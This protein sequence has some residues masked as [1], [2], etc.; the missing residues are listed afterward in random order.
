[1]KLF[2]ISRVTIFFLIIFG[3]FANF[4]QNDWGNTI[5][6][7]GELLIALL[8]L[9]EYCVVLF[10]RIRNKEARYFNV[11][12]LLLAFAF[13]V[14]P[15][16]ISMTASLESDK[17][18]N[19]Y[20][21]LWLAYLLIPITDFALCLRFQ[22]KRRSYTAGAFEAFFLFLSF[23]GMFLRNIHMPLAG[24]LLVL[25]NLFMAVPFY[26]YTT[27]AFAR[28]NLKDG[29]F[30]ITVLIIGSL[31]AIILGLAGGFKIMHLP[32]GTGLQEVGLL[33][34][35]L[36]LLGAMRW[37]FKFKGERV[38]ILRALSLFETRIV[39]VYIA[40][41]IFMSHFYLVKNGLAPAFYER[42]FPP[43]VRELQVKGKDAQANEVIE[44][45][46]GFE[47]DARKNGFL[48]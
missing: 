24:P 37:Q 3:A 35:I 2:T 30:L 7:T 17:F 14:V 36:M 41:L 1:M 39:Q 34:T 20:S 21:F 6:R 27:V 46:L 38:S 32:G 47:D 26:I 10:S 31:S 40:L 44:A 11:L 42:Q 43:M 29:P 25:S 45:Y 15:V 8:F 33:L 9:V 28:K 22:Q 23:L 48:K 12:Q 13:F 4:A 18:V 16:C 19:F 5:I